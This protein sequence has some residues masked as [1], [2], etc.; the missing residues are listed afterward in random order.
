[1][2]SSEKASGVTILNAYR[3]R[4]GLTLA[5][6]AEVLGVSTASAGRYVLAPTSPNHKRPNRA[7][8]ELLRQWS[9]DLVNIANYADPWTPEIDAVWIAAGAF[10]AEAPSD[11]GASS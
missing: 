4:R 6:L 11:A 9:G 7:A 5:G 8:A 2:S 1:M 10:V 3:K